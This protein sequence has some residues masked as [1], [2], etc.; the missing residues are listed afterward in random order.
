MGNKYDDVIIEGDLSGLKFIAYY[1]RNGKI[2]A[3]ASMGIPNVSLF[4]YA[5]HII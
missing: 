1:A 5:L 3:S 4:I 2:V